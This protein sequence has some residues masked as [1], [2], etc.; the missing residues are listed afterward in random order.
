[1]PNTVSEQGQ[2]TVEAAFLI[3][4]LALVLAILVQ[5]T[6]ILYDRMVMSSAAAEGCRLLQTLPAEEVGDALKAYVE[7]RLGAVPQVAPF[8]VHDPCSWVIESEGGQGSEYVTVR[9]TNKL[10]PLPLI[11]PQASGFGQIDADGLLT[12]QVEV[13]TRARASWVEGSPSQWIG[14]W[15]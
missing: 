14:A 11:Q 3:P 9:V 4:I 10:K 5:P 15:E 13:T 2:A 7:R 8:H 12:L 6:I 1:M